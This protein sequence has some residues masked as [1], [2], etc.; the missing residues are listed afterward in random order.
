MSQEKGELDKR[1]GICNQYRD[2][3]IPGVIFAG[4]AG[5]IFLFI[6]S[7]SNITVILVVAAGLCLSSLISFLLSLLWAMT[8]LEAIEILGKVARADKGELFTLVISGIQLLCSSI[9]LLCFWKSRI[10]GIVAVSIFIA[11]VVIF[12]F[13]IR[14][15]ERIQ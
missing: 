12:V 14:H 15:Q 7:L 13:L 2:W 8:R 5:S 3:L 9:A 1:A 6:I 10:L 4:I 11:S